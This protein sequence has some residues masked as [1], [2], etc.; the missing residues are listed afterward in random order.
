MGT[1]ADYTA[2]LGVAAM[3]IGFIW[4]KFSNDNDS[5]KPA[6]EPSQKVLVDSVQDGV[7]VEIVEE[8]KFDPAPGV[9]HRKGTM[10]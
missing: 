1:L 2:L 9:Q 5:H 3:V 6:S 7:A 8:V 4:L 10:F